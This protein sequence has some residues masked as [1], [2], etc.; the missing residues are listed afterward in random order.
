MQVGAGRLPGAAD[1]PDALTGGPAAAARGASLLLVRGGIFPEP[2]GV[3]LG[4]LRPAT[5]TVLG[6]VA[7]V[8]D[9]T[10]AIAAQRAR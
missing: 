1:V 2:T 10:A 4:R 5:M 7:V 3:A 8:S 9:E 6:S